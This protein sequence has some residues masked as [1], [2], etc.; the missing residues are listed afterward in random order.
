MTSD[1]ARALIEQRFGAAMMNIYH[2]A[3]KEAAYNA[4]RYL[5]MLYDKGGLG[6]AQTLLHAS[7]VSMVQTRAS[8]TRWSG[9]VWGDE[10]RSITFT[11]RMLCNSSG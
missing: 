9:G 4:T 6:T 11:N 10:L 7:Q 3:R 8:L 1:Q 5:Q 2:R